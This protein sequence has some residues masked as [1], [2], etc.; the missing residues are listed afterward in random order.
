MPQTSLCPPQPA[1]NC[2]LLFPLQLAVAS[3]IVPRLMEKFADNKIVIRHSNLKVPPRPS[4]PSSSIS[5]RI[6]LF[7]G[8]VTPC[9]TRLRRPRCYPPAVPRLTRRNARALS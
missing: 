9:P 4:R 3:A 8:F 2:A 6:L 1:P 7:S 5:P